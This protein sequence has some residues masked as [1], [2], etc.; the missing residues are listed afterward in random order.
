MDFKMWLENEEM[1]L[2]EGWKDWALAGTLAAGSLMGGGPNANAA[3][4]T[5]FPGRAAPSVTQSMH[6]P[7]SINR[8][9]RESGGVYTPARGN[10]VLVKHNTNVSRDSL[11]DNKVDFVPTSVTGKYTVVSVTGRG[12]TKEEAISDALQSAA[13]KIGMRVS[14]D[15]VVKNDEIEKDQITTGGEAAIGR[16]VVRDGK[17]AS[18]LVTVEV[19]AEVQKHTGKSKGTENFR[20][21]SDDGQ[22]RTYKQTINRR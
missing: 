14:S 8:F 17:E 10:G 3:I 19:R 7:S 5:S 12:T 4:N 2:E 1:S 20:R 15:T 18:G 22:F 13:G 11:T 9:W 6:S 21:L 16:F